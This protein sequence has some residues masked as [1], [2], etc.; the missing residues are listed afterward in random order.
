MHSQ[1]IPKVSQMTG[2]VDVQAFRDPLHGELPHVH[3]SRSCEM[4]SFSTI[5]L[6]KIQWSSKIS[7]WIWS[8]IFGVVTVLGFPGQGTSQVKKSPRLNWATQ[9]LA[10]GIWWCTFPW[11]FCQNGVNF[12]RCLTLQG[13]LDDGLFLYVVEIVHVPDML[14]C[15]LCTRHNK[16]TRKDNS[17]N[18]QTPLSNNTTDSALQHGK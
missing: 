2:T 13:K 3:L 18:E 6:A 8:I 11:C 4:P 7:S 15:S 9:F 12:L 10:G 17:A 14:P 1:K 16:N 5:D